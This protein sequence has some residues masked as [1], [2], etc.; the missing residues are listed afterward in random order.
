MA[1]KKPEQAHFL[2]SVAMQLKVLFGESVDIGIYSSTPAEG[3]NVAIVPLTSSSETSPPLSIDIAAQARQISRNQFEAVTGSLD[4]NSAGYDTVTAVASFTEGNSDMQKILSVYSK[5]KLHEDITK[6]L[7]YIMQDI[8]FALRK[9]RETISIHNKLTKTERELQEARMEARVDK[10][11]S[12]P[13]RRW[14]VEHV[15]NELSTIERNIEKKS[16]GEKYTGPVEIGLVFADIDLFKKFN[17]A[18]GHNAG[19]IVLSEVASEL[20]DNKRSEDFAAR[21]GGEEFLITVP[22][23]DIRGTVAAA[24]RHRQAIERRRFKFGDRPDQEVPL[25]MSFGVVPMEQLLDQTDWNKVI[26]FINDPNN[27]RFVTEEQVEH[28]KSLQNGNGNGGGEKTKIIQP[29]LIF[30]PTNPRKCAHDV[31]LLIAFEYAH[32]LASKVNHAAK[33]AGRNTVCRAEWNDFD[34]RWEAKGPR[35][36]EI[37]D[38]SDS[39]FTQF[40]IQGTK[41]EYLAA[42]Q[43]AQHHLS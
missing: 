12:L 31:K 4:T 39:K 35:T 23:Q 6:Q 8:K 2:Q 17:S 34:R 38:L 37:I 32:A 20:G 13:N 43:E 27:V 28:S 1:A 15:L 29:D 5:G 33:E 21:F 10:L 22:G 16:R 14:L 40:I 3:E 18:Y 9:L 11:T 7:P 24:E 19:D 30:D 41:E 36:N 42:I 25:T 26:E